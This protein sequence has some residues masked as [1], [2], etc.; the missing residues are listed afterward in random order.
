MSFIKL[1]NSK[2]SKIAATKFY[3]I[4][5]N[6]IHPHYDGQDRTY[7]ILFSNDDKTNSLMREKFEN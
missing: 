4:L 6:A 1:I 7:K 2:N 3:S 5:L